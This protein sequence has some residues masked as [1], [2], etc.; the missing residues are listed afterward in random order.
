MDKP[1]IKYL[2]G[3]WKVKWRSTVAWASSPCA[4]YR[5]CMQYRKEKGW[6]LPGDPP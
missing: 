1:H 3:E 5:R 2:N 4:A 6:S